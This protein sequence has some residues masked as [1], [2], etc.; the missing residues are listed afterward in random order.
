M[1]SAVGTVT[2]TLDDNGNY[3]LSSEDVTPDASDNV[4][5][6]MVSTGPNKS[7]KFDN[8]P[9]AIVNDADFTIAPPNGGTTRLVVRDSEADKATI[10]DHEYTL[11]AV[12]GTDK[13]AIDPRII[14]R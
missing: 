2:V 1:P 13:V 4:I 6:T 5:F 9:I 3:T 11:Y 12:C 14:D 7:W 8:P 10:P